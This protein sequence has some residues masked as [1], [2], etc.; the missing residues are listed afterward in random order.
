M[1]T[2]LD[3]IRSGTISA[4]DYVDALSRRE[5]ERPRLGQIA[6][7]EGML[8]ARQV[9]NI[10]TKQYASP[11]RRFGQVAI[12]E[13]HLSPEQVETLLEQQLLRQRPVIDHLVELGRLSAA[14]AEVADTPTEASVRSFAMA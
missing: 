8:S 3:L 4:E 6:I 14:Q 5:A 13:G 2:E 12:E 7:E 1:E 10:L 9:L 11:E